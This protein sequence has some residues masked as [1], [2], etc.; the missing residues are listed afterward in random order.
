[1]G[2]TAQS[3]EGI[4]EEQDL[5]KHSPEHG[6]DEEGR[7]TLGSMA[8]SMEKIKGEEKDLGEHGEN[9]EQRRTLGSTTCPCMTSGPRGE[10]RLRG[11]LR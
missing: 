8:L 11:C 9:E 1:M 4:K 3:M 5:R 10:V 6:G 7:T 2:N